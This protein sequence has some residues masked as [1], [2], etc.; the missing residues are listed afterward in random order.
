MKIK[1]L[2][3]Y[4]QPLGDGRII[5]AAGTS[6]DTRDYDLDE[7]TKADKKLVKRGSLEILEEEAKS[8]VTQI[9]PPPPK[10]PD[11]NQQKTGGSK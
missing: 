5:G 4:P 10:Q 8:P 9:T 7:L 1:N 3:E 6:S 11:G 2:Q